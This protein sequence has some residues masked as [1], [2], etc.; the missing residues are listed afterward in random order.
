MH[1]KDWVDAMDDQVLLG[2]ISFVGF[3]ILMD[4]FENFFV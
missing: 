4:S 1:S 3:V 2:H